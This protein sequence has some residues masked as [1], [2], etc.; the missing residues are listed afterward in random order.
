MS[1]NRGGFYL[2]FI[3]FAQKNVYIVNWYLLATFVIFRLHKFKVDIL[4]KSRINV[5]E[6]NNCEYQTMLF[7]R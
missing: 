7:A 6:N 1:R 2:Y 4:K 5:C 3:L